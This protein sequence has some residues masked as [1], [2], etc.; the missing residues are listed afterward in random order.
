[1]FINLFVIVF[2][3]CVEGVGGVGWGVG[4]EVIHRG[5]QRSSNHSITGTHTTREAGG[6][7]PTGRYTHIKLVS[8]LVV[9]ILVSIYIAKVVVHLPV[10]LS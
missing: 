9:S 6:P 1:M 2:V 10:V 5:S 8:N 4:V 7:R 3:H